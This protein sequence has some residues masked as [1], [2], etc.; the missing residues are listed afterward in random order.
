MVERFDV[1]ARESGLAVFEPRCR[2]EPW[3]LREVRLTQERAASPQTLRASKNQCA[4]LRPAFRSMITKTN[5]TM[6]APP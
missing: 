4:L 5:S 1:L 3:P 2:G 6:I